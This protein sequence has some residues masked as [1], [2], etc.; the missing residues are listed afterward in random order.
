MQHP[1]QNIARGSHAVFVTFISVNNLSMDSSHNKKDDSISLKEQ[2]VVY[3]IQ[4]ALEAYPRLTP[5][6]GLSS[7]VQALV[8]PDLLKLLAQ[9]I[10]GLP[11]YVHNMLLDC[12]TSYDDSTIQEPHE[13]HWNAAKRILRYVQG[14]ITYG[15]HYAANCS[16][17]LIGFTDSDWAGDTIDRK[18]TSGYVLSLGSGPI[19]WSSKKQAAIALSSVEVEYRGVV[20]ATIQAIWLQH[21]IFELGISVHHPTVIWC[22]N[23]STLK[24]CRDPVQQQRTKHIEIHMHFIRELIHDGIIDLQYCPSSEQIADIF[25]K[26]FT[27]QK[28]RFLRDRLGVKDTTT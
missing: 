21:F 19:C 26:T 22:D 28:F 13:L 18:S 1:D 14:T 15:I 17:N 9:L 25:T 20:N 4:R 27:K 5:F 8:L 23:Q 10:I 3:Y 6:E 7:G 2:L 11:E 12:S 24:F 16:L